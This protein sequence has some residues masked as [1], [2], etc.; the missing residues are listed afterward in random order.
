V[1]G[2]RRR[3]IVVNFDEVAD[4]LKYDEWHFERVLRLLMDSN[5]LCY[6]CILLTSTQTLNV[7]KLPASSGIGHVSISLPLLKVEHMY[8]VVQHI[9]R[10]CCRDEELTESSI[11]ERILS[12]VRPQEMPELRCFT[13]LLDLLAGVPRFLEKALFCMGCDASSH[14]F[15]PEVFLCNLERVKDSHYVYDLLLPAVVHAIT[16]K[17]G[18]FL[19]HLQSMELFPLLVT[20]SLFG[21]RFYRSQEIKY[22]SA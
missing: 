17:Y 4:V 3:V 6:F 14:A 19:R 10:L 15:Q 18:R 5:Q 2:D 11:A 1:C 12:D 7:L 22:P 16:V 21:A 9:T 8:Q 20:C 13:Y